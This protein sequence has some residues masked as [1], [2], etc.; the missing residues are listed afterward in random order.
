MTDLLSSDSQ[1]L[2]CFSQDLY[3]YLSSVNRVISHHLVS[4]HHQHLLLMAVE[5]LDFKNIDFMMDLRLLRSPVLHV[6]NRDSGGCYVFIFQ[7]IST[8]N[9]LNIPN[10][11]L[12]VTLLQL[13]IPGED[14]TSETTSDLGVVITY[15]L[16]NY[17]IKLYNINDSSKICQ[18]SSGI[19]LL[20]FLSRIIYKMTV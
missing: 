12:A 20:N 15:F 10:L 7:I 16:G 18:V 9:G 2:F 5:N 3:F 6:C 11:T 19:F 4:S 1:L 13:G 17:F 8:Y 14:E